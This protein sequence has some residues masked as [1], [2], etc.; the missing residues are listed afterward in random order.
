[1]S[2]SLSPGHRTKVKPRLTRKAGDG[3]VKPRTPSPVEVAALRAHDAGISVITAREDGSKQPCFAWKPYQKNPP[4]RSEVEQW[5]GYGWP[6][7]MFVTGKVSGNLECFEFDDAET[8]ERF[9]EAAGETGLGP[10][11]E[12]IEQGYAEQTPSGGVHW[13]YRSS[14][15]LGN[16]KLAGRPWRDDDGRP[17]EKT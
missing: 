9:K 13:L 8:Y 11:V 3:S 17:K 12:R 10:L 14:S 15:V 1:L 4:S 2:N 16:T 6:G 5:F 7:L